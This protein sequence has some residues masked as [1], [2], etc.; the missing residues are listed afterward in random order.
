[1]PLPPL[2][3]ASLCIGRRCERRCCSFAVWERHRSWSCLSLMFCTAGTFS[4]FTL[5]WSHAA[6]GLKWH[7]SGNL[8]RSKANKKMDFLTQGVLPKRVLH[9]DEV[10]YSG[11]SLQAQNTWG[12][13][14]SV[15][16]VYW[17]DIK[18]LTW[19][20]THTINTLQRLLS[21]DS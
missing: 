2:S 7:H 9:C 15:F 10:F 13:L 14:L 11:F 18:N 6:N 1:M 4:S 5:H 8:S 17:L 12:K 3:R 19:Q 21:K 16:L 20:N